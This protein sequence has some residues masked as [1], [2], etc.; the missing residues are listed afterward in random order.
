[1]IFAHCKQAK[2]LRQTDGR[3]D[4]PLDGQLERRQHSVLTLTLHDC[5][6]EVETPSAWGYECV[7]RI[8]NLNSPSRVWWGRKVG[9]GEWRMGGLEVGRL[10]GGQTGSS[11]PR[12]SLLL[13]FC[14]SLGFF[15]SI[16]SCNHEFILLKITWQV[17]PYLT[18]L[19]VLSW[20]PSP[21]SISGKWKWL[22]EWEW[23]YC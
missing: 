7:P 3:T 9:L 4:A 12:G 8:R 6:S 15:V 5:D 19:S 11:I 21:S 16:L 23:K 17:A 1:M 14:W 20:S 10:G 2:K 13:L 22:W 18:K